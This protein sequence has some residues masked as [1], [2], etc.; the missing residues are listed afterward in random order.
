MPP[1]KNEILPEGPRENEPSGTPERNEK[2]V[3]L[4]DV[5]EEVSLEI[6]AKLAELDNRIRE[7]QQQKLRGQ[8]LPE[9]GTRA[10]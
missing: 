7:Q 4:G 2:P 9:D 6:D 8:R 3:T 5:K 10:A 1:P